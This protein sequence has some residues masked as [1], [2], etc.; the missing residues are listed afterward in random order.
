MK[1]IVFK[2]WIINL[3]IS[4]ALFVIYRIVIAETNSVNRNLFETFLDFLDILLNLGFALI[5]LIAMFIS[6]LAFFLNLIG[7]IGNNSYLSLL[8]FIGIPSVCVIYLIVNVLID[9]RLYNETAVATLVKFSIIYLFFT[10]VEFLLFR[11]AVNKLR[12]E[13]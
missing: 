10:V 4:I 12:T 9:I 6:S 1:R 3:L 8:T 5:Y 13:Y 11:K 7:K 2:F